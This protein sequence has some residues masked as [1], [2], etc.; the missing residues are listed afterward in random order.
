MFYSGM[1]SFVECSRIMYNIIYLCCEDFQ[2]SGLATISAELFLKLDWWKML[3]LSLTSCY[4]PLHLYFEHFVA[5]IAKMRTD[6]KI[7]WVKISFTTLQ[8]CLLQIFVVAKML[9]IKLLYFTLFLMFFINL[10]PHPSCIVFHFFLC[11]VSRIHQQLLWKQLKTLLI[12][13]LCTNIKA[14]C[15]PIWPI[16]GKKVNSVMLPLETEQWKLW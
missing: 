3:Q 2:I 6:C 4:K 14:T 15:S 10:Y 9:T 5:V 13:M 7:N 11:T 16:F 12:H 1:I 8:L